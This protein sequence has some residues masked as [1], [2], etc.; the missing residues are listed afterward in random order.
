MINNFVCSSSYI[1][2]ANTGVQ[3]EQRISWHKIRI[4]IIFQASNGM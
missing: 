2:L 1:G 3:I 4:I